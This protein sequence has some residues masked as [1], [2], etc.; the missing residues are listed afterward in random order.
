MPRGEEE[1][2]RDYQTAT[3]PCMGTA[4]R[5][6]MHMDTAHEIRETA[7]HVAH[8]VQVHDST[9]SAGIQ[10]QF[11]LAAAPVWSICSSIHSI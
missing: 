8:P 4:S 5:I 1:G 9:C 3:L 7:A 6:K 11:P 2:L 10:I